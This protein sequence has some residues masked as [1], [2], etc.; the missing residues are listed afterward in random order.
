M[1]NLRFSKRRQ[2][3]TI[4]KSLIVFMRKKQEVLKT[5]VS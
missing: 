3:H 1:R 4:V 5:T 2:L